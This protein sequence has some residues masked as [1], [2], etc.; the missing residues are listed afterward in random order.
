MA[1]KLLSKGIGEA[2]S[3]LLTAFAIERG[4]GVSGLRMTWSMAADGTITGH[5]PHDCPHDAVA[6]R[7]RK[8]GTALGLEPVRGGAATEESLNAYA[9]TVDGFKVVIVDI[10]AEQRRGPVGAIAKSLRKPVFSVVAAVPAVTVS[11][12]H[13]IREAPSTRATTS[14]QT[15]V[16]ARNEVAAGRFSGQLVTIEPWQQLPAADG[17]TGFSAG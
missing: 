6:D 5:P 11:G 4:H 10:P 8:W 17:K 1:R 12:R 16:S 7:N 14:S 2:V 15:R 13:A 3:R 9:G